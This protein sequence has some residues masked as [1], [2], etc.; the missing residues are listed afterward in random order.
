MPL[1]LRNFFDAAPVSFQTGEAGAQECFHNFSSESPADDSPS[2]AEHVYV[3][4]FHALMSGERI[5]TKSGADSRK[6]VGGDTAA[7]AAPAE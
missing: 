6:F 4:V 7:H 3:V 1:N 5:M 2:Q